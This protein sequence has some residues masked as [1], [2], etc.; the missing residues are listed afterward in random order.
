MKFTGLAGLQLADI[1]F[2]DV[3]EHLHLSEVF[4]DD[5]DGGRLQ[6]RGDGLADVDIARHHHAIDRRL[7]DGVVEIHL[8][9]V[10]R[11]LGLVG[12]RLRLAQFATAWLALA[13][14][15]D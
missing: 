3:R 14:W 7:D 8:G 15:P 10:H 4:R 12:L 9:D 11:R 13:L 5:E 2:I 6:A 1:G